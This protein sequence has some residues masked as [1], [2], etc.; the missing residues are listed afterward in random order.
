MRWPFRFPSAPQP[1]DAETPDNATPP[2]DVDAAKL[3]GNWKANRKDGASFVLDLNKDSKFSWSYEDHGKKQEFGGK[4]TMDGPVLVL[5]RND[6]A[7]MPGLITLADNGFNFK[8]YG[9]SSDDPG[10]DFKN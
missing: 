6:G 9:G 3:V 5:E 4:Y 8:L 7:Q 2:P 1:A 10:L